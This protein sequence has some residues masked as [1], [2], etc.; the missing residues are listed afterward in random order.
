MSAAPQMYQDAASMAIW[1]LH[2]GTCVHIQEGAFLPPKGPASTTVRPA[3]AEV[4]QLPQPAGQPDT[5]EQAGLG[6]EAR[7]FIVQQLPL[8]QVGN[9][10]AAEGKDS[11]VC[12]SATSLFRAQNEC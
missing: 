9:T 1:Q 6:E 12:Q 2:N 8:F 5:R 4:P 11:L 10:T 7:E 3:G